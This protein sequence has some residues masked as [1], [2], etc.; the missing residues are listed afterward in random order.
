MLQSESILLNVFRLRLNY[1]GTRDLK[2]YDE[3][4]RSLIVYI[5]RKTSLAIFDFA[6]PF[7][8]QITSLRIVP[9]EPASNRSG[10]D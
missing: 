2:E 1:Q 3:K 10:N 7:S 4:I 5:N 8:F 6:R 9:F